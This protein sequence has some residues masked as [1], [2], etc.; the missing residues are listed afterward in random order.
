[1]GKP[2]IYID[3][4]IKV[5][6]CIWS[7]LISLGIINKLFG[8]YEDLNKI[9]TSELAW[10]L[11]GTLMFAWIGLNILVKLGYIYVSTPSGETRI[12][13][14]GLGYQASFYTIA[15]VLAAFGVWGK[16]EKIFNENDSILT[17]A[18]LPVVKDEIGKDP[19]R[20]YRDQLKQYLGT[21]K[22]EAH[23]NFKVKFPEIDPDDMPGNDD[24]AMELGKR[25]G[26]Q[27][28]VWGNSEDYE[29]D[30]SKFR[31]RYVLTEYYKRTIDSARMNGDTEMKPLPSLY[32]LR[33]GY[34]LENVAYIVNW[35]EGIAAYRDFKYNS[36]I[37][38]FE[39][40]INFDSVKRNDPK[41]NI[42]LA[43]L[44][45]E[46]NKDSVAHSYCLEALK[47]QQGLGDTNSPFYASILISC[48]ATIGRGP[49]TD[50][51]LNFVN[52]GIAILESYPIK[53]SL[54][55]GTGYLEKGRIY[56]NHLQHSEAL[57]NYK[58]SLAYLDEKNDANTLTLVVLNYDI[59][60]IHL[61]ANQLDTSYVFLHKALAYQH[62][63]KQEDVSMNGFIFSA[64]GNWYNQ[65][66]M[67]EI[68]LRYYKMADYIFDKFIN[69]S[70]RRSA[71]YND[72]GNL[73][74]NHGNLDSAQ[75]YI[76]N[77]KK[78]ME[79]N[80][81]TLSDAY[82]NMTVS[83][84]EIARKKKKFADALKYGLESERT[85]RTIVHNKDT[86]YISFAYIYINIADY[87]SDLLDVKMS[88]KY[89]KKASQVL[90]NNTSLVKSDN[91]L[92]GY[93]NWTKA[94]F[95]KASGN[96][97]GARIACKEA[98]RILS[99]N[100]PDDY[101]DVQDVKN[102]QSALNGQ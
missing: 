53:D 34:L 91:Q 2:K 46:L 43:N 75:W 22:K 84:G 14:V 97:N 85:L 5:I 36:A 41:T 42:L 77:G 1:M 79:A 82:V 95:E 16:K 40:A 54:N 90:K 37:K 4:Q 45:L 94:K 9:L 26:A 93:Y 56:F 7:G 13:N 29:N 15:I 78:F 96:M 101:K 12:K 11:F 83:L 6:F 48:G 31:V 8:L 60:I 33:H 63:L 66:G 62:K 35:T 30:S 67:F 70:S 19:H 102:L 32:Q 38:Y 52:K 72:I 61:G 28:V 99:K 80:D 25:L 44:Y 73:F 81:D 51:A 39:Q 50:S 17:V 57:N 65:K 88:G 59:G 98:V 23:C 68:A 10:W 18:V 92:W 20:N 47:N 74:N 58:K 89:L 76:L 86:N 49:Y 64:L 27:M 3:K 69:H 24:E 87:S 55:L 71:L 100:F 21:V